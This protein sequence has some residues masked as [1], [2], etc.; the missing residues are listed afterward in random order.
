MSRKILYVEVTS[1]VKRIVP[2]DGKYQYLAIGYVDCY[3]GD[4]WFVL[5]AFKKNSMYKNMKSGK[6]YTPKELYLV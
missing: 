3:N 2:E 4:A 1:V 6:K 5:P